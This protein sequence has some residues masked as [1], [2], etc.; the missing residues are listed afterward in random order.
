MNFG[1]DKRFLLDEKLHGL[2]C[3][4]YRLDRDFASTRV[5]QRMYECYECHVLE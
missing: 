4:W 2:N 3:V 5:S 1:D